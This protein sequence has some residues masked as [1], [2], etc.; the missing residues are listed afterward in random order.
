MLIDGENLTYGLRHLLGKPNKKA[1]RLTIENFDFRG[2][3]EELLAD[4][5]PTDILWFGARLRLYDMTDNLKR[6][7]NDAIRLQSKFMNHIQ[8]QR[9]NFIKV[10]Y[11]RAR[12]T[13]PCVKCSTQTWRLTEKGVDV[14]LAVRMVT[15]SRKDTELVVISADTDLLPAFRAASKLGAK[16]MHIGYEF[17]QIHALLRASDTSRTITLP[18]VQKFK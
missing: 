16:I 13:E 11:L 5:L 15:E 6:K 7:S 8:T 4:D 9:I 1:K 12:E 18:L 17:R 14:G 10:G 3:I 2:M